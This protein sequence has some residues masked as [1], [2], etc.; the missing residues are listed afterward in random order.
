MIEALFGVTYA[1]LSL[2]YI[3]SRLASFVVAFCGAQPTYFHGPSARRIA[4]DVI[5]NKDTYVKGLRGGIILSHV[6]DECR[7]PSSRR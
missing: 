6:R 7:G 4:T 5:Y 2:I 3:A 1:C